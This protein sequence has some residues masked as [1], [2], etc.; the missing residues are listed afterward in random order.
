MPFVKNKG[1]IDIQYINLG[2][3]TISNEIKSFIAY[4]V[5]SADSEHLFKKGFGY[6]KLSIEEYLHSDTLCSY[7]ISPSFS[8]IKKKL[9]TNILFFILMY[10]TD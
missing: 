9:T 7:Y 10:Q 5:N 2:D 6:I 8:D 1:Q 3:T 4:E